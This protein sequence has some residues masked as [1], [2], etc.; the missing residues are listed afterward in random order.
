MV[1]QVRYMTRW[2]FGFAADIESDVG[3]VGLEIE[4]ALMKIARKHK[5]K[6]C[7]YWADVRSFDMRAFRPKEEKHVK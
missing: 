1:W 2:Y 3:K 7:N 6:N 5:L 4:E